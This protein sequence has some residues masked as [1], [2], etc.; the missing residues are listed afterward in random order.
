LAWS[1]EPGQVNGP[2][3]LY[4]HGNGRNGHT[5]ATLGG[6]ANAPMTVSMDF[7]QDMRAYSRFTVTRSWSGLRPR[8]KRLAGQRRRR[9]RQSRGHQCRGIQLRIRKFTRYSGNLQLHERSAYTAP[10]HQ[11]GASTDSIAFYRTSLVLGLHRRPVGHHLSWILC[12][13]TPPKALTM[14]DT[15]A[16]T[17]SDTAWEGPVFH[18]AQLAT[19]QGVSTSLRSRKPFSP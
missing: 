12:V 15:P 17:P 7:L 8:V 14:S 16:S 3:P 1:V 2:T 10:D 9:A 11:H 6:G 19:L 5:A 18:P 4:A 13:L